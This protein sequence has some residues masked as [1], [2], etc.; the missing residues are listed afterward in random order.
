MG[1]NQTYKVFKQ[2]RKLSKTKRELTEWDKTVANNAT[3]KSLTPKYADN[4]YNSTTKNKSK[5][6]QK[7]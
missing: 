6:W 7:T 2:Q 3:N 5:N 4:S 1:P